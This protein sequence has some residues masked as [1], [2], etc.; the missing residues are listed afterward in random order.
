MTG[1]LT[2]DHCKVCGL[3]LWRLIAGPYRFLYCHACD[4][5]REG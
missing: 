2:R 3:R 4:R 5:T 1:T